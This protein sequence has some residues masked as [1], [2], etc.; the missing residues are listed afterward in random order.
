MYK[1][2]AAYSR[3]NLL[4][5][6]AELLFLPR[7][8]SFVYLITTYRGL[9]CTSQAGARDGGDTGEPDGLGSHPHAVCRPVGQT[10][11]ENFFNDV[12]K[13]RTSAFEGGI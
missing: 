6:N 5:S 9:L 8:V 4:A 12:I 1:K 7:N 10:K 2:N 13:F 11:L 3:C